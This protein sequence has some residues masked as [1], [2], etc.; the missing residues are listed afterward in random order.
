MQISSCARLLYMQVGLTRLDGVWRR[1]AMEWSS[2]RCR[3]RPGQSRSRR[4]TS[5]RS[6][7]EQSR[8]KRRT[9]HRYGGWRRLRE[10]RRTAQRR[11]L[12]LA[13]SS[14]RWEGAAATWPSR[15]AEVEGTRAAIERK[16]DQGRGASAA[17]RRGSPVGGSSA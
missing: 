13:S 2:G 5:R 4:S 3:S 11:R 15:L 9:E 7:L 8:S 10:A 6:K 12:A 14:S 17:T 1:R 16:G